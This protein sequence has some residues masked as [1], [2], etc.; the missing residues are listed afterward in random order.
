LDN[1]ATLTFDPT[2]TN[3][4]LADTMEV[5]VTCSPRRPRS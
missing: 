1:S 5:P 4:R 3:V 2:G